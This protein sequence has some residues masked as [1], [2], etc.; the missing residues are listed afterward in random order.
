MEACSQPQ[1]FSA[2]SVFV[3]ARFFRHV[4]F[5]YVIPM[6][7]GER[8]FGATALHGDLMVAARPTVGGRLIRNPVVKS[9]R[10]RA[11]A[12]QADPEASR[13]LLNLLVIHNRIDGMQRSNPSLN[14]C[15]L[16]HFEEAEVAHLEIFDG[17][18]VLVQSHNIH[19]NLARCHFQGVT[20]RRRSIVRRLSRR[21]YRLRWG[22]LRVLT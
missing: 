5:A 8:N 17:I 11:R 4:R 12:R 16:R 22:R 10:D 7:I 2:G 6:P 13:V 15:V 9:I 21:R 20:A 3:D 19:H 18:L 1:F 14:L